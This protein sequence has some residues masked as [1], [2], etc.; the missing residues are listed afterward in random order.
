[1]REYRFIPL[2][3]ILVAVVDTFTKEMS[4]N[5]FVHN[6]GIIVGAITLVIVVAEILV[7]TNTKINKRLSESSFFIFAL[8]ALLLNNFGKFL[9]LALHLPDNVITMLSLYLLVPI[10]TIALCFIT[11]LFFSHCMPKLCSLLTGGR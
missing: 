9:L 11:Y 10:L 3:Y 2:V 4:F 5:T 6:F 1:M 7:R 8:H